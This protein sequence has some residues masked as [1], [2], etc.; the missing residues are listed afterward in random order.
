MK[1]NSSYRQKILTIKFLSLK[2]GLEVIYNKMKKYAPL[3]E[4][5][6]LEHL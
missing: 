6:V 2:Q 4:M 3:H 5:G 1:D